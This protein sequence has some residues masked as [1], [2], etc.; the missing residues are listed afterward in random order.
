MKQHEWK[1]LRIAV[2]AGDDALC[3]WLAGWLAE[4]GTC[5][6]EQAETSQGAQWMAYFEPAA[7]GSGV[8]GQL[9]TDAA[10]AGFRGMEVSAPEDVAQ[11]NWH[12]GWREHF[13]PLMASP[14]L[15]VVPSWMKDASIPLDGVTDLFIEPGMAFG[16]GTHATTRLCLSLLETHLRPGDGVLDIGTGSSILSIAAV[17]LGAG[18][19]TAIDNDPE[20]VSNI[21]D[22]RILNDIARDRIEVL[23][24]PLDTL[25]LKPQLILCN[26]LSREFLPLLGA[27]RERCG[28]T[29]R[30][31]LSGFLLDEEAE[32]LAALSTANL[33]TIATDRMDEWGALVAQPC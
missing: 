12:D 27:I 28:Q 33:R 15:R 6:I 11:E 17:K 14:R 32:V 25:D 18:D 3:D 16:T 9:L 31:I 2:P 30:V 23:I 22:N 10:G 26:M 5:G 8:A 20:V 24:V 21:I 19:V 29:T 7:L 4:Q 1:M 13:K